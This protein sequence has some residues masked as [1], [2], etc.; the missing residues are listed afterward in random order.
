MACQ[1]EIAQKIT[2]AQT[3]YVLAVKANQT[4]R[5]ENIQDEFNFNKSRDK[6]RRDH[7]YPERLLKI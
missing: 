6:A 2:E 7:Q 1:T 4:E 5:S 3:N